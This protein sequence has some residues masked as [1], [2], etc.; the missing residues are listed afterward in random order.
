MVKTPQVKPDWNT[1]IY[2]G[3]GVVATKT[4]IDCGEEDLVFEGENEYEPDPVTGEPRCFSC[5]L[6]SN[7]KRY[8][9]QRKNIHKNLLGNL[10]SIF[11]VPTRTIVRFICPAPAGE[12]KDKKNYLFVLTKISGWDS[13]G[14]IQ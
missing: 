6:K 1:G 13:M 10:P 2:I 11:F 5:D 9:D 8:M 14:L 7:P 12:K 3:N 4:C